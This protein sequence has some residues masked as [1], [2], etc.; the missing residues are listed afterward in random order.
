MKNQLEAVDWG[1]IPYAEAYEKQKAWFDAAI[2]RKIA[3]EPVRNTVIFCEHPHVIT[4]GKHGL[5]ANLLFPEE[6]L[7]EKRVELFRVDRGGD[8]T[9]HGPGQL[10]G[11]PILD[12]ESFPVGL[13]EYIY[14]T[15]EAVIRLLAEYHIKG[16]HFAGSTGVW[17]DTAHP[18]KAR[19]ICAIGVKSSRYVTMHGFAL[20]VSTDLAYFNLINP[21][22]FNDKGVTS[23]EKECRKAIDMSEIKTRL[24]KCFTESLY[25][26]KNNG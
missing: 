16:E 25:L 7:K 15:E 5:D 26:F 24:L 19:K 22:G 12:L 8:I 23:M 17:I 18:G 4:L 2:E 3:G 20:N 10:V 1:L 11:Y 14:R 9:Y 6:A 13:K 21:C